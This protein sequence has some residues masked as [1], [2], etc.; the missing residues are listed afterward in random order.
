[1]ID[2]DKV[3]HQSFLLSNNCCY[4]TLFILFW[5]D[6]YAIDNDDAVIN[7]LFSP[8]L[9]WKQADDQQDQRQIQHD[10]L[11]LSQLRKL[12]HWMR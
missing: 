11:I 9:D 7:D 10:D 4:C 6:I 5:I 1:M 12:F 3:R 2:I 8:T